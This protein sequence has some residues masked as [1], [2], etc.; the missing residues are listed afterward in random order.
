MQLTDE[1]MAEAEA[2][3]AADRPESACAGG[4]ELLDDV[5]EFVARFVA[6]P[7]SAALNAVTLWAAHG[8]LVSVGENSPRLALLSPEPGSGKTRTLEILELLVPQPMFALSASTP[9]TFRSLAKEPRVLLFDE[10]DAI[11]GR[12]GKDDSAEDLRALLNAGHRR[13]ASIPRCV[14][15]TH[16]VIDFPVFAAVALAGLGDLPDTLMSRSVIIRMRRRRPS[17]RIEPFRH[18]LHSPAGFKLRARLF[19]WCADVSAE[20]A[21][22]FPEMPDGV[23]DRSA[24]VWEPLLAIADAAGGHWPD[25]ARGACVELVE[26]GKSREASLGVKLLTDLRTIFTEGNADRMSTDDIL[27]RLHALDES[28]WADLRGKPLDARGL[29]RRLGQYEVK[30]YQL[31]IGDVKMRGY[32][33]SGSDSAGGGLYDAFERYLPPSEGLETGTNGTNGTSQVSG[34]DAATVRDPGTGTKDPAGTTAN[35][36][37]REVPDV[38]DVPL[39]EGSGGRCSIC[40]H[41]PVRRGSFGWIACEHQIA[42][43]LAPE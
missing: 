9:A 7:T 5:R 25:S 4:A 43:G 15:P 12:F 28:P 42:A 20:V 8:H 19:A 10:V 40:D 31:K 29:A 37:T 22:V 36:V 18:R 23:T 6:F 41:P 38:P 27:G 32:S 2:L 26:V 39:I 33:V 14:G 11:F 13:G 34:L 17:E 3:A 30:P 24:D 21:R 35:S 16:D 1:M